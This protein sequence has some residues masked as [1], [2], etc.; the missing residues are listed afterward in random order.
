MAGCSCGHW[1]AHHY[2]TRCYGSP[3]CTCRLYDGQL[4][5]P[6][7][8]PLPA[9]P[10]G[11]S[12]KELDMARK[13]KATATSAADATAAPAGDATLRAI[14]DQVDAANAAAPATK[15]CGRCE[16]EKPRTDFMKASSQKDGLDRWCKPCCADYQREWRAKKAAA[17][18]T[19]PAALAAAANALEGKPGLYGAA[20]FEVDTTPAEPHIPRSAGMPKHD[21]AA[22]IHVPDDPAEVA[23]DEGQAALAAAAEAATLA[24]RAAW[25]DARRRQRAAAKAAQA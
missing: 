15:T 8:A 18:A 7:P 20:D 13:T 24:R 25:A 10:A 11:T 5:R 16:E 12:D 4:G 23:T 9:T 22:P 17:A 3:A 19:T 21:D 6:T 14:V 2:P 1:L